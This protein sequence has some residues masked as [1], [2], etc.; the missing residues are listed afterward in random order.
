MSA[1]ACANDVS[2]QITLV[3]QPVTMLQVEPYRYEDAD[4]SVVNDRHVVSAN[5]DYGV[6]C[7]AAD[8]TIQATLLD[9]LPDD[10]TVYLEMKSDVGSSAGLRELR[11]GHTVGLVSRVRGAEYNEIAI[12]LSCPTGV[13]PDLLRLNIAYSITSAAY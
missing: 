3:V 4:T 12:E 10:V 11:Y 5:L 2:H 13:E 7:V 6:T 9:P 8:A 1:H